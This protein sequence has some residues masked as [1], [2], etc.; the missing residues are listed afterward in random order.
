MYARESGRIQNQDETSGKRGKPAA[1]WWWHSQWR[2]TANHRHED[3]ATTWTWSQKD[4]GQAVNAS[5]ADWGSD[6]D[7]ATWWPQADHNDNDQSPDCS[8]GGTAAVGSDAG[9]GPWI[10]GV[11]AQRGTPPDCEQ[12]SPFAGAVRSCEEVDH[13]GTNDTSCKE[14]TVDTTAMAQQDMHMIDTCAGPDSVGDAIM[15]AADDQADVDMEEVKDWDW[16]NDDPIRQTNSFKW[17]QA[18]AQKKRGNA[19]KN[20]RES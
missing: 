8:T 16:A 14:Q 19:T 13:A 6:A 20:N 12:E 3:G 11:I 10:S 1:D 9:K 7:G 15:E 5:A 4:D 17:L 18:A 2:E